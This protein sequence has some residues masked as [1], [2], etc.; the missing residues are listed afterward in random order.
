MKSFENCLYFYLVERISTGR[1]ELLYSNERI[2]EVI[3]TTEN[4]VER[5]KRSGSGLILGWRIQKVPR[6]YVGMV[7]GEAK[8]LCRDDEWNLYTLDGESF[9]VVD[10]VKGSL[11]DITYE[12]YDKE[13]DRFKEEGLL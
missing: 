6:V 4:E 11:I 10:M 8:Y 5:A 1:R 13:L 9:E 7:H 12:F 3:G 2:A